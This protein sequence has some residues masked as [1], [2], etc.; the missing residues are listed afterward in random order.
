MRHAIG[1]CLLLELLAKR[2]LTQSEFARRMGVPRQTV[3]KWIKKQDIMSLE[4]AYRASTILECKIEELYE[5]TP[6][7]AADK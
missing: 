7:E 1:R 6:E 3:T 2:K 4:T 5:W